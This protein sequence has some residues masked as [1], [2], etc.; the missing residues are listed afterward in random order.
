M[1][2]QKKDT[3]KAYKK[4]RKMLEISDKMPLLLNHDNAKLPV[5]L[6]SSWCHQQS[7]HDT[8]VSGI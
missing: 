4:I 3:E 8:V 2:Q 1:N 6:T 5:L 7:I